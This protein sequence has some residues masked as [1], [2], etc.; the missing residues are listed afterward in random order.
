MSPVSR[1]KKTWSKVK[2]AKFDILEVRVSPQTL[3]ELF[4]FGTIAVTQSFRESK[5]KDTTSKRQEETIR[6]ARREVRNGEGAAGKSGRK[7]RLRWQQT[8]KS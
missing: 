5:D 1:L 3:N 8:S 2:T 6:S 7:P 4:F